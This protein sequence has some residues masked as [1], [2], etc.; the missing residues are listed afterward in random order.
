VEVEDDT[1]AFAQVRF[2]FFLCSLLFHRFALT[3]VVMGQ[4]IVL[5]AASHLPFK[6]LGR[7]RQHKLLGDV[8]NLSKLHPTQGRTA[9]QV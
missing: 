6:I 9:L 7:S 5:G 1:S 2:D 3:Q 8:E 4:G